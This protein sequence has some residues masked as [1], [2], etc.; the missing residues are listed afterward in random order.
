MLAW[1]SAQLFQSNKQPLVDLGLAA[2]VLLLKED[3][4]TKNLLVLL[5]GSAIIPILTAILTLS[6]G[7]STQNIWF[8]VIEYN[9]TYVVNRRF[10]LV[11]NVMK[12]AVLFSIGLVLANK[13]KITHLPIILWLLVDFV[14][15][16]S[17]GQPFPHYL[18]QI[19]PVSSL[20]LAIAVERK[21]SSKFI[22]W[23]ALILLAFLIFMFFNS[24]FRIFSYGDVF[25]ER[26]YY[27]SF[28]KTVLG[29]DKNSFNSLFLSVGG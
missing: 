21:Y 23:S 29:I 11:L 24:N 27:S 15:V 14:G 4:R 18:I 7:A 1:Q 2:L 6:L 9:L 22:D 10:G 19:L 26:D 16:I 13:H 28:I 3:S 17:G 8:S 5:F 12:I 25:K 20:T